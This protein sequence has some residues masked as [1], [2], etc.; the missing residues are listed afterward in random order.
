MEF[1][2]KINIP[3]PAIRID[4]RSRLMLFGSC[5]AESIGTLLRN[6]KFDVTVNPF[7]IL[8]NPA[9]ISQ[10]IN[11]ILDKQPV[12]ESELFAHSGLYHSFLHHGDFSS[13]NKDECLLS[14]NKSFGEAVKNIQDTD[15][16][17]ITFGTAHVFEE[18]N[19][20]Q[21]VANCHKLPAANF[22]R[23]RLSVDDIAESW[24]RLIQRLLK[25]N[26]NLNLIFTVSPIRHLKDGLHEN[27]LSKSTLLLA[28]D[29]LQSRYENIRYFPSYEILIDDLRDY[30]FYAGDMLHPNS[31]AIEYIWELFCTT[32][33]SGQTLSVTEEWKSIRNAIDHKPFNRESVEHKQFLRQTLLK[34]NSFQDKYPYLDC[35]K[36]K[37]ILEDQLL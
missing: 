30:R 17:F 28:I 7:G 14:I 24:S 18:I 6:N 34:L 10:V 25:M 5:F 16:L 27:Q 1:R 33:F 36:E 2:T 32:Y 15:F 26:P 29:K 13:A 22:K 8:Y 3:D 11:R 12:E 4:H 37:I 9:S 20:G 19:S 35:S 21:I 23:Y 31:I